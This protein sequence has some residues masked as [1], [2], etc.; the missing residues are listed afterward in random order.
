MG[1]VDDHDRSFFFQSESDAFLS[2]LQ[3]RVAPEQRAELLRP[4]VAGDST[5]QRSQASTI[6]AGQDHRPLVFDRPGDRVGGTPSADANILVALLFRD[7]RRHHR[8][9]SFTR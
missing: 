6:P 9:R 7:R 1:P 3:E 4:F 5:S 8:N 2:L